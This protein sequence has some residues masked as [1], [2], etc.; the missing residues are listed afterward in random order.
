MHV[1]HG[2]EGLVKEKFE[3]VFGEFGMLLVYDSLEVGIEQFG[4]DI[5]RP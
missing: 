4:D 2:P 1:M 5:T 3:V